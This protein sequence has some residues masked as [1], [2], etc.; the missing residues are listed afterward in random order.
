MIHTHVGEN[1]VESY[2]DGGLIKIIFN[3]LSS[4]IYL[5]LYLSLKC[6]LWKVEEKIQG[7]ESSG[8]KYVNM[9]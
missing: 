4:H 2:N 3:S 5:S 8:L 1:G 6:S 7:I 9:T